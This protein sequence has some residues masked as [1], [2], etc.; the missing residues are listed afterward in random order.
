MNPLTGRIGRF[1]R[2]AV[3]PAAVLS[4][5]VGANAQQGPEVAGTWRVEPAVGI[6]RQGDRGG[7]ATGRRVG[8]FVGVQVSQPRGAAARVTANV[9]Y[10]RVADALQLRTF[11][12]AGETRTDSYDAELLSFIA[13]P[14]VA[15]TPSASA[16]CSRRC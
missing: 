14:M 11:N 4:A 5:P 8:Q 6:W 13:S 2:V 7:S 15:P 16:A 9:G 3:L 12:S 1:S 10:H